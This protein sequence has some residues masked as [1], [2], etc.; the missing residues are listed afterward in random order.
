MY[1]K[2]RYVQPTCDSYD[3]NVMFAIDL[4]NKALAIKNRTEKLE[5]RE[6]TENWKKKLQNKV[7]EIAR[8]HL[9]I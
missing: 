3:C 1:I 9:M 2:T 4:A 8:K 7:Q 6:K 5:L